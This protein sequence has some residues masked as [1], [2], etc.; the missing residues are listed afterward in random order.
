MS[1][2]TS[3]K[4]LVSQPSPLFGSNMN[5]SKRTLFSD[6]PSWRT[7]SSPT[8][9]DIQFNISLPTNYEYRVTVYQTSDALSDDHHS[10]TMEHF[11]QRTRSGQQD[12]RL[13]NM[14]Q[15]DT[16][17]REQLQ[18]EQNARAECLR[19]LDKLEARIK[20]LYGSPQEKIDTK[21]AKGYVGNH[22]PMEEGKNV[23]RKLNGAV[24]G[25]NVSKK[26]KLSVVTFENGIEVI[27]LTSDE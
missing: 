14:Y 7:Q 1:T 8:P 25:S 17:L 27:D 24:S 16:R 6:S 4:T 15:W 20:S 18:R 21:I 5:P 9:E 26:R 13:E 23:K 22:I 11:Q 19:K 12:S 3:V 10:P 2:T